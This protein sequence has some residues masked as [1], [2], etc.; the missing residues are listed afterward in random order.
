ML[1]TFVS[2]GN[3][4]HLF[5]LCSDVVPGICRSRCPSVVITAPAG[6]QMTAGA[7]CF[8]LTLKY[9][10]LFIAKLAWLKSGQEQYGDCLP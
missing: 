10:L 4:Q 5:Q 8:T 2:M 6:A 3:G 7:R 9:A 1:V